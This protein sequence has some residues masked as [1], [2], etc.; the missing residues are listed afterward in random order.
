MPTT[1]CLP[2]EAGE[3]L[4]GQHRGT[5][6][7]YQAEGHPAHH[8]P[9]W[10]LATDSSWEREN[11]SEQE[12]H[13]TETQAAK[14][15]G[16]GPAWES[17]SGTA[18]PWHADVS[19]LYG[20]L[21]GGVPQKIAPNDLLGTTQCSVLPKKLNTNHYWTL[22]SVVWHLSL[23]ANI[24]TGGTAVML[25]DTLTKRSSS[26]D[27]CTGCLH[28]S[29]WDFSLLAPPLPA[30]TVKSSATIYKSPLKCI[31]M[32]E[33]TSPASS[34]YL[35]SHPIILLCRFR[36]MHTELKVVPLG[37]PFFSP[38]ACINLN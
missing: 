30:P 16:R 4:Q 8:P 23:N 38:P 3:A 34:H 2:G 7:T 11:V 15:T 17:R 35:K 9:C 31:R 13:D 22:N 32:F 6:Y 12:Q 37:P 19:W 25:G 33:R 29:P 27:H 1:H 5:C 20:P 21:S 14:K 26:S 28:L 10:T 18:G 36:C 24:S